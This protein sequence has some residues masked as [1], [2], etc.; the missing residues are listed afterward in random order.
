MTRLA[1]LALLLCLT[2]CAVGPGKP[3]SLLNQNPQ[4]YN[5]LGG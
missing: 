1:I 3:C 5:W 2:G 4:C